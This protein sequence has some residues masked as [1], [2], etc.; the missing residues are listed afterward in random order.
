MAVLIVAYHVKIHVQQYAWEIVQVHVA[1]DVKNPA[2][3]NAQEHVR[4]AV[5]A[6]VKV[7]VQQDAKTIAKAIV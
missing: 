4:V 3:A 1:Q 2:Q 5:Q 6:V 7:H